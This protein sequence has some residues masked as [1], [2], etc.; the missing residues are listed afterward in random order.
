MA[1]QDTGQSLFVTGAVG[2]NGAARSGTRFVPPKL[3]SDQR[4][5]VSQPPTIT[6]NLRRAHH[7]VRRRRQPAVR[8]PFAVAAGE[9]GLARRRDDGSRNT[10]EMIA[11]VGSEARCIV[12]HGW[13]M[14]ERLRAA[15]MQVNVPGRIA[16]E[17]NHAIRA[18]DEAAPGVRHH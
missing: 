13:T 6:F 4:F 14:R 1:L 2:L 5:S 17:T 16:R 9:R 12:Q 18:R 15:L 8:I 7:A 3:E 11:N 10:R